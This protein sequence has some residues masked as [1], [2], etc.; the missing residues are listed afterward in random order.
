M[1][2]HTIRRPK[3]TTASVVAWALSIAGVLTAALFSSPASAETSPFQPRSSDMVTA[4]SLPTAQING[5]AWAQAVVG[6]TVYVGGSFSQARPAGAAAGTNE[7]PRS[8]L[9][10]YTLSTGVM[11]GW[12]P[13][14]NGQVLAVEVSPDGSKV[15][16]GG[17]FTQ[18]GGIS[19][20]RIA[21]FSTATGQLISTFAPPVGYTV[22]AIVATNT[23]VYVGGSFL[24]VGAQPRANLAAFNAANGA[25]LA[26]A[27]SVNRQVNGLGI[28][29]DG[30]YIIAGG[31]FETVNAAAARGL[32]KID[33]TTGALVP[34]PV[35][36]SNAGPSSGNTSIHVKG[37]AVYGTGYHFGAGGNQEGP[38]KI[39][40]A[41]GQLLWVADCHG[42]T[43]DAYPVGSTVYTVGH[44]HY[45]GNIGGGFPQYA[46][47]RYQ[48]GMAFST[49]ATGTNIREVHGY[50]N[51][52]G[53][54]SPSI[55]HW[56]P[57]LV[58]G[59]YTGQAQ[60]GWSVDGNDQYVVVGGEFP[61]VNGGAQQGLTRFATTPTAPGAR[62]PAFL[63]NQLIPT[64]QT[65]APG[66]VK[67][68][69]LAGY[70]QDDQALTYRVYRSPGGNIKTLV[71]DS[72]W[73]HTPG[74]HYVDTGLT[75]GAT[76]SYHVRASDSTGN[77]VFGAARSITVPESFTRNAYGTAVLADGPQLYWP[78]NE[79][80]GTPTVLDH[81]GGFH[82]VPGSAVTRAVAD[83]AIAGDAAVSVNNNINGR[84]Y[85][86]GSDLAP[87]DYT[88][89]VWFKTSATS[90]RL[91]GFGDLQ[92]GDS[93]HRDRQIYLTNSGRVHFGVR[94]DGTKVISSP[95]A[96]NNNA[97][98]QAVATLSGATMRLYV[99]GALVALRHDITNPEVYVGHWRLGGDNQADWP[100]AGNANF[101]GSM[102]ELSI[103]PYAL[104]QQQV[105]AH[106]VAS[107]RTS[108]VPA[109]P[110][111]GYG[112]D[113]FDAEPDLYWRLSETSGTT[114]NDSGP[115]RNH[116]TYQG[117]HTKNVAGALVGVS[118]TAVTFNGSSGYVASTN[119][120]TDPRVFSAEAW[121]RTT[122][123]TGGKIIGFGDQR[124][125]L[126][127]NYD[128]HV[129]LLND[130][131]LVFGAYNG[132]EV[133]ITS[134]SS[135]R[136]GQW[137]HVVA[138]MSAQGMKLYV[139]GAL[140][141]TDPNTLA[142]SYTGY[143]RVGG[144]RV[145]SGASSNFLA[146]TI[147][148][149]AVYSRAL[150][151]AEVA[152]HYSLGSG[153]ATNLSPTAAF[154]HSSNHLEVAFD[155]SGS[156]DPDG[157]ISS[158]EWDF[159]DGTPLGTSVSPS[160]TYAEAGTH[161]VTLTVTDNG[162]KS[163]SVTR[164]VAVEAPPPNQ[165][166][167]GAITHSVDDLTVSVDGT[168]SSDVDGTIV[169]YEWDFG[170]GFQSGG[171]TTSHTFPSAG[172]YPIQLRVTDD[173]GAA[174]IATV[175][176][177]ANEPPAIH[178]TDTF[179]RTVSNSLGT[180]DLGGPWTSTNTASLF[181]VSG[182]VGRITMPRAGAEPTATLGSVV[183]RDVEATLDVAFDKAP[184]G[185]G[186]YSTLMV[187]RVGTSD[188]R[189]KVRP[190][191]GDTQIVLA[192]SVNNVET[193]LSSTTLPWVYQ[194]GQVI[195]MRLVVKGN[196]TTALTAKVWLVGE[197]EPAAWQLT[198]NDSTASLQN[199]GGV[200]LSQYLSASATNAP[201][202]AL[203]DNL[204]VVGAD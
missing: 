153:V 61:S 68:S 63:N 9:M 185:N 97:W 199:A 13:G 83:G 64:L 118:N 11:T 108:Q 51:W 165:P 10:A 19:R 146:G 98:H 128:R 166:P 39:D 145:W 8:N 142:Q 171:A 23:T 116:G 161:N 85:A 201:V 154:V 203:V 76:Y 192:R 45:C 17:D 94:S 177:T 113:V 41:T 194:P 121:F 21:A 42:D 52:E 167:T 2:R 170:A 60:A 200:A 84:I 4:D 5:V 163:H 91:L 107:G 75:P 137:H 46:T 95:A 7:S 56:L 197:P 152:R 29:D 66:A 31:A 186:L 135:Y 182:G 175:T 80:A 48:N 190:L 204:S 131:R 24:G 67:I 109:R 30:Q 156:Q 59:S 196:G 122:S 65:V 72:K 104:T 89:E 74:L 138:T 174:N 133:R 188:Y 78:L 62:G 143:W 130:G 58:T 86:Q 50:P 111:D 176:V 114:A 129:F 57:T 106:Y 81:A 164:Q 15:Y 92:V 79:A 124:T 93:G 155:G 183:A 32:A 134:P 1:S 18:V 99:D 173:D 82:G 69:W 49:E 172:D 55:K 112:Q 189:L 149:A 198:A 33:A 157:T 123:S 162:G 150:S 139:D 117:T 3:R 179:S 96:Y 125:S 73:W 180:A 36:I 181:Q 126:S 140:V 100:S 141:G 37:G 101:T 136:N 71:A 168:G 22:R 16:V 191:S 102:D 26:W 144:D 120:V 147:D 119:A 12:N 110:A 195:R 132:Q 44:A 184:T 38:W 158:Y 178:A 47:W 28:S 43:Y 70:D 187:R 27:P 90:G 77:I 6:N 160:H 40:V 20:S 53:N 88:A 127:S 14:A 151:P 103:Y 159:G 35:A 202:V 169:S 148:E 87:T 105:N 115:M 54:P 193:V 34:W 25:L